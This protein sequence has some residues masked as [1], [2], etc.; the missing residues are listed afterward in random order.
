M[1]CNPKEKANAIENCSENRF[2]SHE[3]CD[4]KYEGRVENL[5]QAVIASVDDIPL[6]NARP[7][8]IHALVKRN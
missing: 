7:C 5:V 3:L 6:R 1:S 2:T 8:D 4:E